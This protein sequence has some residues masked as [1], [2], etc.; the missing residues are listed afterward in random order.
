M[1][2][3]WRITFGDVDDTQNFDWSEIRKVMCDVDDPSKVSHVDLEEIKYDSKKEAQKVLDEISDYTASYAVSI[4]KV[5]KPEIVESYYI[6]GENGSYFEAEFDNG[7]EIMINTVGDVFEGNEQLKGM[8][9]TEIVEEFGEGREMN[10]KNTNISSVMNEK[11]LEKEVSC[12][13]FELFESMYEYCKDADITNYKLTTSKEVADWENEFQLINS[14]EAKNKEYLIDSFKPIDDI[15]FNFDNQEQ[16]KFDDKTYNYVDWGEPEDCYLLEGEEQTELY[17]VYRKVDDNK[18]RSCGI[19]FENREE[20]K[21]YVLND[22]IEEIEDDIEYSR[23]QGKEE[24][25]KEL[26]NELNTIREQLKE[27]INE[28]DKEKE[29]EK[30]HK[31][32]R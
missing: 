1:K 13:D 8:S 28:I 24:V 23:K 20:A 4:K 25:A 15:Y 30:K 12:A 2:K 9:I 31:R 5:E 6:T 14:F 7:E 3:K 10:F 21:K 18:F 32:R 11:G 26:E 27:E 29:Y 17:T 22:I 16:V 19:V